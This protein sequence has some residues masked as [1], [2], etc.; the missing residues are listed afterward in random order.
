MCWLYRNNKKNRTATPLFPTSLALR[1][2]CFLFLIF[3]FF[4]LKFS[5]GI[6]S[7]SKQSIKIIL[8]TNIAFYSLSFLFSLFLFLLCYI[9]YFY[10]FI[11]C[12]FY[13]SSSF[14]FLMGFL[15]S[16]QHKF[17]YMQKRIQ[18]KF[19]LLVVK[20]SF[21]LFFFSLYWYVDVLSRLSFLSWP[22]IPLSLKILF[23]CILVF[24]FSFYTSLRQAYRQA[25]ERS[26]QRS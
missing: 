22:F 13:S 25:L 8:F 23:V 17:S 5:I 1:Y 15:R 11:S 10:S 3:F 19:C 21:S 12:F 7:K 24:I 4:T 9:L 6:N 16:I 14:L 26:R 2:F 20:Y 18:R